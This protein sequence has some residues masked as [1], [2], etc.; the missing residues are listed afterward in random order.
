MVS[1][2]AKACTHRSTQVHDGIH[3][4]IRKPA[5]FDDVRPRGEGFVRHPAS[6]ALR[7]TVHKTDASFL[8]ALVAIKLESV[9]AG[10]KVNA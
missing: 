6:V 4:G 7:L 2:E 10:K 5:L 9:S 8:V 1:E 3:D